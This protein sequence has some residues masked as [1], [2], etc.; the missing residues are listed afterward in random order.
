MD[1]SNAERVDG[2]LGWIANPFDHLLH[3]GFGT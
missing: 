3:R 2:E 1:K